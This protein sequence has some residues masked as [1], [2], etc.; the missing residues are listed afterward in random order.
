MT[1]GS[2]GPA[3]AARGRADVVVAAVA[4]TFCGGVFALTYGFDA[5]PEALMKGLGAELFPRLVLGVMILLAALIALGIGTTRMP[6]PAPLP[7][8]VWLTGVVLLAF[9]GAVE[10]V[11]MWPACIVV[12]VG[13]GRLWGERSLVKLMAS[14]AGLC[15]ALYL[16]FVR[17]L[18]TS[19]PKGL[20][21]AL[22]P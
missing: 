5:V 13:L 22:W 17:F 8:M 19:F 16:L 14:A 18:G 20:L 1:G 7:R 4:L 11:G 15:G 10:L 6:A 12:L 21:G 3:G 9:M 2:M